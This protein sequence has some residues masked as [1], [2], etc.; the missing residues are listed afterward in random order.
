MGWVSSDTYIVISEIDRVTY[1]GAWNSVGRFA[2]QDFEMIGED[3]AV[4]RIYSNGELDVWYA[5][6]MGASP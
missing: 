2:A 3:Y 1:E 6:P 5:I 4:D